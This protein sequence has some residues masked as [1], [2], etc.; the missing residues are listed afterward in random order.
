MSRAAEFFFG[1]QSRASAAAAASPWA[2]SACTLEN[3]PD[4]ESCSACGAPRSSRAGPSPAT[5]AQS[6]QLP[7][8][9]AYPVHRAYP[10]MSAPAP[11]RGTTTPA[12]AAN[13]VQAA[14]P[15]TGA[16]PRP[17]TLEEFVQS[18]TSALGQATLHA[19][20]LLSDGTQLELTQTYEAQHLRSRLQPLVAVSPAADPL[21][22][23]TPFPPDA[24]TPAASASARPPPVPPPTTTSAP[25]RRPNGGLPSSREASTAPPGSMPEIAAD[26]GFVDGGGPSFVESLAN[27]GA[28]GGEAEARQPLPSHPSRRGG[29]AVGP[30]QLPLRETISLEEARR[31][32][33]D[34]AQL[35]GD[36]TVGASGAR[37]NAPTTGNDGLYNNA[38]DAY[39]RSVFID[40]R[41]QARPPAGGAAPA[42]PVVEMAEGDAE[43]MSVPFEVAAV[44]AKIRNMARVGGER[45]R[46]LD[47][48]VES[49]ETP[50]VELRLGGRNE[51]GGDSLTV[52][53]LLEDAVRRQ[54]LSGAVELPLGGDAPSLLVVPAADRKPGEGDGVQVPPHLVA[55][56]RIFWGL[57]SEALGVLGWEGAARRV[58]LYWLPTVR[59]TAF[60]CCTGGEGDNRLYVNVCPFQQTAACECEEADATRPVALARDRWATA[61]PYYVSRLAAADRASAGRGAA[62]ARKPTGLY[63]EAVRR[64]LAARLAVLQGTRVAA[65]PAAPAAWSPPPVPTELLRPPS[66][67]AVGRAAAP[68]KPSTRTAAAEK[69]TPRG[70]DLDLDVDVERDILEDMVDVQR[71]A[72]EE[73]RRSLEATERELRALEDALAADGGALNQAPP[74]ANAPDEALEA[75]RQI[76]GPP[77]WDDDALMW[78]AGQCR[79]NEH[80]AVIE[81]ALSFGTAA[82]MRQQLGD[83]MHPI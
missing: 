38:E 13:S 64:R 50:V 8:A 24:A 20:V 80:G 22:T 70:L 19:T 49:V 43:M 16:K 55:Y 29:A 5:P 30:A 37:V 79:G 68:S 78:L 17:R 82:A 1:R 41:R 18:G 28:A 67:E 63:D 76:F 27:A 56:A 44:G 47:H 6:A 74:P 46:E 33:G 2:C 45:V 53:R 42:A 9:V 11:P 61:L 54:K 3:R 73:N 51:S 66:P 69:P 21:P 10:G 75:L 62:S 83:A 52:R 65:L 71:Q 36:P 26:G 7:H 12:P 40:P 77:D 39:E 14:R 59:A 35:P 34:P 15:T 23:A 32:Y 58:R 31:R 57:L 48:F 25:S 4:A 60:V 81:M 72:S